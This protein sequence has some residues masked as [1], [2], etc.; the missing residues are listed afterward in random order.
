MCNL[1]DRIKT[2]CE[3]KG[4]T[5]S[6]LCL[7][8]GMSKSVLSDLKSGR[9]KT[10]SSDTLGRIAAHLSVS[11]DYLLG[12]EGTQSDILDEVDVAF[13][14]DFKELTPE[15]K[16]AVRDMVRAMRAR[17]GDRVSQQEQE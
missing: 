2:A 4:I 17:R 5:V 12:S 10:L 6:A 14:G 1:Y 16:E 9:K 8:L 11:A 13:Y 7:Q 15:Q 3:T